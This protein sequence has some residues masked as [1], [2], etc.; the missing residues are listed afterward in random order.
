MLDPEDTAAVDEHDGGQNS[1]R[2]GQGSRT[3]ARTGVE[4]LPVALMGMGAI[5]TALAAMMWSRRRKIA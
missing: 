3:L 4:A 2:D 5:I 1:S